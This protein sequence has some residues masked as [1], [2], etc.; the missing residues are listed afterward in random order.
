M[1]GVSA[2]TFKASG[3]RSHARQGF[4]ALTGRGRGVLRIPRGAAGLRLG[5]GVLGNVVAY[6]SCTEI[7]SEGEAA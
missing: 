5:G 4:G 1:A 6:K 7:E 2:V 3:R